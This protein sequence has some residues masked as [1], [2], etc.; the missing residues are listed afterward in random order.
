MS[1]TVE[2]AC[3]LVWKI[4]DA[5]KVTKNQATSQTNFGPYQEIIPYTLS[6]CNFALLFSLD[7]K[8]VTNV[9]KTLNILT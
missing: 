3:S 5:T 1:I 4:D 6:L 8:S 7:V 2:W 9:N